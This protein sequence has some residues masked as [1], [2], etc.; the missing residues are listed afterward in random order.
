[1]ALA[2]YRLN[3]RQVATITKPGRHADGGGLYLVVDSSGA[4]RWLYL[5]RW[6]TDPSQRGTGKLREMGLG[7]ARDVPLVKA[8]ELATKAREMVAAGVDP[9]A[10]RRAAA[11]VKAIPIFGAVADE[12]VETLRPS[13]RNGKHFAQWRT[14]L[15]AE[16]YDLER[17]RIDRAAHTVHIAAL[18][19]LRALPVDEVDTEAVL[20][21]LQPIWLAAPETASR[22][23]GRIERVL[24]AAR[25]RGFRTGENPARWRGH[26]DHVLPKRSKLSR[27]HHPAAPYAEVPT[28]VAK[29]RATGGVSALAL[30]FAILTAARTGEVL[31]ATWREIDLAART[32]IVPAAR[33]K[34]GRVHRVPICDRAAMIVSAV[35]SLRR[36]EN[37]DEFIFPG[38]RSGRPLSQMSLAMALRRAEAG[39]ATPHGMRS[40]FRDWSGDCTSFPREIAEAAL[41]HS[42][43]NEVEAAY[44]RGDALQKR[45]ELMNAW[46]A[47][48]NATPA[49]VKA[50]GDD[51]GAA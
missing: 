39:E 5:F 41:A 29:L 44:R 48:L 24:D 12:L 8:R 20:S 23:R 37:D 26:L 9:I 3:A 46:C 42:V 30:E 16:P 13:F 43:G 45:R 36:G 31:G 17:V 11:V 34:S 38:Q 49:P 22:V 47:F 33:M 10:A 35:A 28:I 50:P 25:V 19:A 21:V 15:G 2:L 40:A 32:W 7:S 4:R 1:M 6:K 14:S 51:A 18:A 27:G